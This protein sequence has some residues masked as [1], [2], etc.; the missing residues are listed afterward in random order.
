MGLLAVA[1]FT[2]FCTVYCCINF[3]FNTMGL[4]LVKYGSAT[5]NSISYAIIF[6]A[7]HLV[8]PSPL[9]DVYS[10]KYHEEKKERKKRN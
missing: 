7:F 4:F 6:S 8:F 5:M 9:L 2:G 1:T 3:I 10:D